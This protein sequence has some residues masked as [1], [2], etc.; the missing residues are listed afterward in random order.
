MSHVIPLY[1]LILAGGR[2]QRMGRDK[3]ILDYHGSPQREYIFS[4]LKE[5]CSEVYLSCK[6]SGNISKSLN[7][8]PDEYE[9]EGPLNGIL[10]AFKTFSTVAWISVPI[11]MPY[12]GKEIVRYLITNRDPEKLATCFLD[13][14]G[15]N[16]EPL[17]TIW[18]PQAGIELEKFYF[19]GGKSPRQFLKTHDVKM[20]ASPDSRIHFNVNTPNDLDHFIKDHSA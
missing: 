16:P 2:S 17:F 1:G 9:V 12:V 3:S 10:T 14:E 18:E 11:D 6:R 19:D 4:I 5:H 20:I 13:S 8:M 15:K 7:P